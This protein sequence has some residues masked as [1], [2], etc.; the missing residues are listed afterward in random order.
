MKNQFLFLVVF[1]SSF[2]FSQ[3]LNSY[4]YAIV[5]EKFSF[6]KKT[7]EIILNSSVKTTLKKYGFITLL[8]DEKLPKDANNINKLF[9]DIE[10]FN[11]TK[12]SKVKIILK[13]SENKVLFTSKEGKATDKDNI[14][15]CNMAYSLA[16][17]SLKELNHKFDKFAKLV[18]VKEIEED[19][20]DN[21]EL[22]TIKNLKTPIAYSA[23]SRKNGYSLKLN[24]EIVYELTKTSR[25][26]LFLA[27]RKE[28]NGI[29][30]RFEDDWYF[31]YSKNHEIV[32]ERIAVNFLE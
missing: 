10:L 16:S 7:N 9:V 26:E 20:T 28:I 27:V 23:V 1:I 14:V 8:S 31:E 3:K 5:P 32:S 24:N 21:S 6:Q 11:S 13:D 30:I 19:S 29:V 17:V 12:I 18:D 15:A 25:K 22:S 2:S 4:K